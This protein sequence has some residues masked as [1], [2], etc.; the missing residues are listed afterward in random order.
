[1]GALGGKKCI[2]DEK[3]CRKVWQCQNYSVPLPPW[4]RENPA[5]PGSS[6]A[7]TG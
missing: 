7:E 6:V 5:M 1:M 4:R 3:S 2:G